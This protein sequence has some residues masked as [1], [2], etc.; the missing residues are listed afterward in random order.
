ML[1]LVI[2][3]INVNSFNVS[4]IGA[5]SLKTLVKVEGVTGGGADIICMSDIRLGI[6][7]HMWNGY[8]DYLRMGSIS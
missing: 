8:S 1:N 7:H 3:Y 5:G 4:G 2:T 6:V